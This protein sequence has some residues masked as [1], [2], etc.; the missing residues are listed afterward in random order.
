MINYNREKLQDI[1]EEFKPLYSEHFKVTASNQHIYK[2]S[3]NWQGYL[4]IEKLGWLHIVT[5]RDDTKLIGYMWFMTGP[6]LNYSDIKI[7]VMEK[8]YV[9]KE[10]WGQG[11]GSMLIQQCEKLAKELGC[12]RSYGSTKISQGPAP[13]RMMIKNGYIEIEK[14]WEKIL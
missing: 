5:V 3:P 6:N 11:M 4:D 2:S 9:S 10:Y 13:E 8:Y 7:A 14:N 12:V 1:L